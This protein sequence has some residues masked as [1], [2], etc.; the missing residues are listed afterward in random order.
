MEA[1]HKDRAEVLDY[2][3]I[4]IIEE[5]KCS[6]PLAV[7]FIWYSS[8]LGSSMLTMRNIAEQIELDVAQMEETADVKN[9]I[10]IG[11]LTNRA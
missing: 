6:S 8:S 3:Y 2:E 1:G 7:S 11:E 5:G 4:D 10:A 9:K